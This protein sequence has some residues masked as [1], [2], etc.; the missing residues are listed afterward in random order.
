LGEALIAEPSGDGEG[1][2]AVVAEDEEVLVF[3]ELF[4]G[5]GGD[6]VHRDEGR[7]FNVRGGVLPGLADVEEERWVGGGEE[8]LGLGYGEFEVHGKKVLGSRY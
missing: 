8:G 7:R 1:A 4:E 3:V 2:R 5:A 6:L